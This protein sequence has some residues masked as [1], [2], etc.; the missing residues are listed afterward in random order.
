MKVFHRD[1]IGTL[2]TRVMVCDNNKH[3]VIP[4]RRFFRLFNKL[5]QR[6]VSVFHCIFY[7]L[8]RFIVLSNH[9]IWVFKRAMVRRGKHQTKERFTFF[10]HLRELLIC[11]I[12]QIF[13]RRSPRTDKLRI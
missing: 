4:I 11:F 5:P 6:V 1:W 2:C 8:F 7:R 13:I 3:G 12:E 10:C 9:T